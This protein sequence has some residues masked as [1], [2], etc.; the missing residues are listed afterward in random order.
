MNT[1]LSPLATPVLN[2]GLSLRPAGAPAPG[3]G[4][5]PAQEPTSQSDQ[6]QV[7]FP[8]PTLDQAA[9]SPPP[10]PTVDPEPAVAP[11]FGSVPLTLFEEPPAPPAQDQAPTPMEKML[12]EMELE[13]LDDG[14]R[15]SKFNREHSEAGWKVRDDIYDSKFWANR[16]EGREVAFVARDEDGKQVQKRGVVAARPPSEHSSALFQLEGQEGKFNTN[17]LEA[18]ALKPNEPEPYAAAGKTFRTRFEEAG[19][20]LR[21]PTSPGGFP[22]DWKFTPQKLDGREVGF[23]TM[24]SSGRRTEHRGV[25]RAGEHWNS[26]L[27]TLEGQEG[28][29]NTNYLIDMAA[30]RPD[31]GAV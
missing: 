2:R 11:A 17:H 16:L 23:L 28:Q 7:S 4:S 31:P 3:P 8:P 27:F 10:P 22:G 21:E 1:Q 14:Y 29:F 26:T 18:L 9:S 15:V 5:T 25:L 12:R 30:R 19:W 20:E 13:R 24:D 6:V